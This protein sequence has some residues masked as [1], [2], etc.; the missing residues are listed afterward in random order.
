M[1]A[2]IIHIIEKKVIVFSIF[3]LLPRVVHTNTESALKGKLQV[4]PNNKVKTADTDIKSGL[5]DNGSVSDVLEYYGCLYS[6]HFG[7]SVAN[8]E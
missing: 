4:Y 1:S 6:E 8:S 5:G 2:L 7:I 3:K